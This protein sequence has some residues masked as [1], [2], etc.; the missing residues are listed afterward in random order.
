MFALVSTLAACG[1]TPA[2]TTAPTTVPA[3]SAAT[4][5][6]AATSA[7]AAIEAPAA[8]PTSAPAAQ[9]ASEG[10]I[11]KI[12][13]G[14]YTLKVWFSG[15]LADLD[16]LKAQIEQFNKSQ[17]DVV[18]DPVVIP[19]G[20]FEDQ[21]K[22][23]TV[24]KT[25]PDI[26]YLDGPN[27]YNYSWNGSLRALDSCLPA[28]TKADLLPSIV[29][30]GTYNGKLYGVGAFDSGLALYTRKSV[31]QKA[32]IRVP[33]GPKDAWTADEFTA[34][35]KTLQGA[36]FKKPLDL[37]INYGRGEWYTYGF[38]PIIQ[39]AGGDLIKRTD[40]QSADGVLNGEASVKALTTFQSWFKAGLVDLNEDDNAFKS[41]RSAISWVGFWEFQNYKKV[42]GDDLILVP[43]PNFGNGSRTGMGSWQWGITTNAANMDAAWSFIN[44]LLQPDSQVTMIKANGS[45]PSRKA[46]IEQAPAFAPGGEERLYVEQLLGDTVVPRPQTPAYPTITTAFAQ[47][48]SDIIDGK[49]V[50]AALDTATQTIDQDIKDNQGYPTK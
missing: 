16:A 23:A 11:G 40:F 6:P 37:K 10:C 28:D 21:V 46:A 22:S 19:A 12:S 44:F 36:G 9:A 26:M 18:I 50:K 1:S 15:T 43:L 8:A 41:G 39:S 4:A 14:P 32:G 20:S 29:N 38:S 42:W 30:Q 33:T 27:L 45:I 49:D 7:P 35:L 48:I 34:A 3:S 25:L 31:L 13:G 5:A 47:A 24:S 17:K 2:T